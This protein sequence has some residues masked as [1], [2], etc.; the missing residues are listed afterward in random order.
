MESEINVCTVCALIDN[1]N[2]KKKVDWCDWCA[3]WI[4][5]VC[6]PNW[7]K[8]GKAMIKRTILRLALRKKKK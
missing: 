7:A 5:D 1:D 6:S 8:R 3:A 4:C 2:T